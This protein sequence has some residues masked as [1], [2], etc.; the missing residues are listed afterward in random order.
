MYLSDYFLLSANFFYEKFSKAITIIV[1][2]NR[3]ARN[4]LSEWR[5]LL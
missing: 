1:I 2:C 3:A 4:G 5:V